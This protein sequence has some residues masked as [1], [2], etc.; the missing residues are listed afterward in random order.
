MSRSKLT[1]AVSLLASHAVY[2]GEMGPKSLPQAADFKKVVFLS[3]GTDF[4]H[5][6]YSQTL[7]VQPPLQN[8]YEAN[9]S[10]TTV[11][12]FGGFI[13]I[14][15]SL[16]QRMRIQSGIAAYGDT[17]ITASGDVWQFAL[18]VFDNFRY[19]YNVSHAR[20]MF[21]NKLMTNLSNYEAI[22][23]YLSFELGAAF[24][25]AHYYH[26]SLIEPLAVPMYP[27]NPKSTT[28]FSWGVGV[29]ADYILKEHLRVGINYQFSDLGSTSL[30]SSP[31]ATTSQTLTMPHLWT[32]QVHFQLT[33]LI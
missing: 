16:S 26:E 3:A 19:S 27:F 1:L 18:P 6:G 14:E 22:L 4:V 10:W 2:A 12:D 32:N 7:T 20:V 29:G 9:S 25:R 28:S 5:T 11:G 13:G 23:P 31:S 17:D 21:S 8:A 30:G 15:K 24:N 33:Y